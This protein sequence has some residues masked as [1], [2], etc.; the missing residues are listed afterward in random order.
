MFGL[1]ELQ[2]ITKTSGISTPWFSQDGIGGV[3]KEVG[4]G[5]GKRTACKKGSTRTGDA[6]ELRSSSEGWSRVEDDNVL[7]LEMILGDCGGL[8]KVV[9]RC[10][11]PEASQTLPHAV[12]PAL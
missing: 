8:R 5:N 12:H 9:E 6:L 2:H 4:W 7:Q 1:A 3:L 11:A 10:N